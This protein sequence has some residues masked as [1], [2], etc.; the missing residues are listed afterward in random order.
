MFYVLAESL[1][2]AT[3]SFSGLVFC[4]AKYV[5]LNGNNKRYLVVVH[6]FLQSRVLNGLDNKRLYIVQF[7]LDSNNSAVT[8]LI[9]LFKL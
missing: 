8:R 4:V 7:M 3:K 9:K 2:I 6:G 1:R 5:P